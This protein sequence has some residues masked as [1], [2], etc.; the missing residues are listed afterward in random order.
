MT[1][2]EVYLSFLPSPMSWLLGSTTYVGEFLYRKGWPE[3]SKCARSTTTIQRRFLRAWM[4]R[5]RCHVVRRGLPSRECARRHRDRRLTGHGFS[6]WVIRLPYTR[7]YPM[8]N[9]DFAGCSSKQ[10]SRF[11]RS[12]ATRDWEP[13]GAAP[14][15]KDYSWRNIA[16]TPAIRS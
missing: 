2:V 9:V 7:F 6:H 15:E 1:R 13:S 16:I 12:I 4:P 3:P 14:T 5:S 8:W 10:D 11:L